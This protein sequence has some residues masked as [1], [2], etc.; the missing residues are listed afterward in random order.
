MLQMPQS[1]LGPQGSHKGSAWKLDL[2]ITPITSDL[3]GQFVVVEAM[4]DIVLHQRDGIFIIQTLFIDIR[5]GNKQALQQR[6][7]VL[8][9]A[10]RQLTCFPAFA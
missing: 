7:V 2:V 3:Q 8:Q 9:I 5:Y 1:S 10:T 6:A 4:P